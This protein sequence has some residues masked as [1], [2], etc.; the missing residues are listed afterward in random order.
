MPRLDL[1]EKYRIQLVALIRS[2]APH[3]EVWAYG[4]RVTVQSHDTSD[5]DLV[6]RNPEDVSQ[7]RLAELSHLKAALQ[8]SNLPILVDVLDWAA[9]PPSFREEIDR[10]HVTLYSPD[11]SARAEAHTG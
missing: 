11:I 2:H 6:L 4:S 10:L 9:I 5:L 3:A 7:S 1:P 8:E